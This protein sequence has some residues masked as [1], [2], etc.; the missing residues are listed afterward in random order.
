METEHRETECTDV[1]PI[2]NMSDEDQQLASFLL[3]E[4]ISLM[5]LGRD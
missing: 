1:V 3:A 5:V 4:E 2:G